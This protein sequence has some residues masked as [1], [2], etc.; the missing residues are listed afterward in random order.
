MYIATI[1]PIARGIPFDTLTY[2]S[3]EMLLAG[4]L[5][6]MPM[7][8]RSILGI[9]LETETLSQAKTAVKQANFSLK[10]IGT[11]YGHLSYFEKSI[12]AVRITAL[13]SLAPAGAVLGSVLS[14]GIFDYINTEKITDL[15]A[16]T[17]HKTEHIFEEH[18]CTG[19]EADRIDNYKRLT[20]SAF[21]EKKSVL[22]VAPSI[23]SLELWK[24]RLEKGIANHVVIFH[25][26]VTKKN[27]RSHFA[28]IKNSERPLL[29]FATPGYLLIPR[30]DIGMV[31]AEDESSTF[32]KTMDRYGIDIR[33]F[34]Q[35]FCRE[36][37]MTLWWGDSLP[38][39]ETLKRLDANHLSRSF[40]P[41]K[42]HIVPVEPY[43]SVLPTE[44]TDLISHAQ[45]K[46]RRIFVYTNRKGVAPLSRCSDCGTIVICKEC[47]LP[48]VLRTRTTADGA[49]ER[50]FIC[51]HCASTLPS[52]HTCTLCNSWNITPVAIGTESIAQEIMH[53]VGEEHVIA[54][55]DDVTPDSKMIE[56]LIRDV[57]QMK[58]AV[59]VG[60]IK[61]LSYLKGIH[62][63]IV[64]FFDRLLS[65]PSLYT[66][67]HMLRLVMECNERSSEGVIVMTRNPDFP[68]IRQ[69]EMRKLNAIIHDELELRKELG[70]PPFGLLLKCSVTVPQ[71]YRQQ[72]R[73]RIEEFFG[74]MD[75]VAMPP[76]RISVG[77]M[78][79]LMVW[80]VKTDMN[81]IEEEGIPL[82]RFFDS[83]RFPYKI[84]QNPERL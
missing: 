40:I 52:T 79:V 12:E 35:H 70:Y 20:R 2:F 31:I 10:K 64:P 26:K 59:I 66:T 38:R 33:V 36:L 37:Q 43:R 48:M 81:Y 54:I 76:R 82:V 41:E 65:T 4:T 68:L 25:S 74:E 1:I 51:S 21:A 45:K 80:I 5:V 32:Y 34:I 47:S 50:Y 28:M 8:K 78:K 73:E 72:V 7:G 84:E 13:Q 18:V 56:E 16:H 62:Y 44:A 83:L 67:E 55:D 23:R 14:H 6:A 53:L 42:L 61:A 63:T 24:A 30:T 19:I 17:K 11:V 29:I 60:T 3:N 75:V 9:V 49:G 46:K 15:A 77:S 39:F 27:L 22:F 69:L 71:V 57:Q 58:F